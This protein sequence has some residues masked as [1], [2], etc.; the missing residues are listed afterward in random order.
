[1]VALELRDARPDDLPIVRRILATA[2]AG[3]P[4][5][6]GMY[7]PEP[8]A[9]LAGT[10]GEYAAWPA[11]DRLVVVA[12]VGETVVGAAGAT[13]AGDCHHCDRPAPVLPGAPTEADR[14]DHEFQNRCRALHRTHEPG[15]H[16]HITSV[17][18]DP[19]VH[20]TG[21][22]RRVV[23]YVRERLAAEDTHPMLLECLTTRAEFYERCGF[24]RVEEFDDPGG[25]DLR[26]VLMRHRP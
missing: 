11:D 1:M 14:I 23:G 26:A 13:V 25:P 10:I 8:L 18:V 3:E 9:R 15:P 16:A 5:A 22:G 7:G 20:G 19:A 4:F 17:A 21:I 6:T 24:D 12:T 2:F